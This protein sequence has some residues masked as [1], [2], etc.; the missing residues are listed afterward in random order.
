MSVRGRGSSLSVQSGI[1]TLGLPIAETPRPL[2][3]STRPPPLLIR[4]SAKPLNVHANG[5]SP[6]ASKPQEVVKTPAKTAA[7]KPEEI[8]SPH[9]LTAFV[10]HNLEFC[11]TFYSLIHRMI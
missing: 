10:S 6:I 11:P 9:E 5:K 2:L 8:S 7:G 3:S 1:D 4:M